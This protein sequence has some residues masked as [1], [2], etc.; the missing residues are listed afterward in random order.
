MRMTAV[1]F[2]LALALAPIVVGFVSGAAALRRFFSRK[3]AAP[4]PQPSAETVETPPADRA[5]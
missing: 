3:P 2:A 4:L 5:E 1:L